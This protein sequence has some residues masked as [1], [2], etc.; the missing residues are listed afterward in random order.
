M[1]K[2]AIVVFLLALLSTPGFGH[3]GSGEETS[4]MSDEEAPAEK[5]SAFFETLTW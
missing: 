5:I 2:I 1:E 4:P 3:A